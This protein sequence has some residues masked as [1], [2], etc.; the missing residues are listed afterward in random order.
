MGMTPPRC[1]REERGSASV[2]A[3]GPLAEFSRRSKFPEE[4]KASSTSCIERAVVGVAHQIYAPA[5][6]YPSTPS[7]GYSLAFEISQ[8]DSGS[9]EL[10]CLY[11]KTGTKRKV[12]PL[13]SSMRY[14]HKARRRKDRS[15]IADIEAN[16]LFKNPWRREVVSRADKET[17]IAVNVLGGVVSET[18]RSYQLFV[19]HPLFVDEAISPEARPEKSS[20]AGPGGQRAVPIRIE[21][22]GISSQPCIRQSRRIRADR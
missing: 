7:H 20:N 12:L 11:A 2:G 22:I 19:A 21:V 1:P 17:V 10:V 18:E 6:T 3:F 8:V 9:D 13:V 15:R 5:L 16:S 4:S 14:G